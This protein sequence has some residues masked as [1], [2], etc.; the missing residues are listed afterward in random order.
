M[1]GFPRRIAH[2]HIDP[3]SLEATSLEY[4]QGLASCAPCVR[5]INVGEP[6]SRPHN[7]SYSPQYRVARLL[8][9]LTD[10]E[11]VRL[12]G[13]ALS[14]R[15]RVCNACS[16][17]FYMIS[18]T[19]YQQLTA[20]NLNG[21]YVSG[22][23]L[24]RFVNDN[25][26]TLTTFGVKFVHLTDGTWKSIFAGLKKVGGLTSLDLFHICQK[27]GVRQALPVPIGWETTYRHKVVGGDKVSE[28]LQVAIDHF[29]ACSNRSA[30]ACPIPKYY[31]VPLLFKSLVGQPCSECDD[32]LKRY[33]ELT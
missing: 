6:G 7:R 4:M 29:Q 24:R 17:E 27:H 23:R 9:I 33:A 2:L 18:T 8:R 3:K 22:G 28:F 5:A 15:L 1:S 31:D 19:P 32:R 21:V 10:V 25:A 20:V 14:P 16:A 30:I 13:C 12:F 26:R 11:S